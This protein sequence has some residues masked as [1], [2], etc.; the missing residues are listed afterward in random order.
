MFRVQQVE[1]GVIA[2]AQKVTDDSFQL[3]EKGPQQRSAAH[4]AAPPCGHLPHDSAG[5][6]LFSPDS[7]SCDLTTA[8][9]FH[10]TL[11]V[12]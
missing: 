1:D 6:M 5:Q 8:K 2:T 3:I 9:E 12:P 11:M 10:V 7:L 4:S